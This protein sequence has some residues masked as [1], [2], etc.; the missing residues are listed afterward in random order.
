MEE[1][2]MRR[3]ILVFIAVLV[4]PILI[5]LADHFILKEDIH[6]SYDYDTSAKWHQIVDNPNAYPQELIDLALRNKETIS[7]VADY[8][9]NHEKDIAINIQQEIQSESMPLFMQWDKRWGYKMYGDQMMAIDG[10]GPTCLSMVVSYLTQNG[11]Y[12]P[13]YM[14]QYSE[15]NGYYSEAGTAW[16]LMVRGAQACGID[17]KEIHLDK[18]TVVSNLLEGHP[19]ICSVSKGTFTSTGHFIVL[20]EYKNHQI[21]VLDPN[22]QKKSGY[23]SF[24]DLSYQIRNLW[25]YSQNS[26]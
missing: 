8:P 16:P 10:C 18:K 12:H 20:S 2:V 14:A 26:F 5:L 19:I 23:Y 22:S 21:K 6:L 13:Y 3:K 17:V 7:F 11:R 9:E 25:A 24:D 4:I 15:Q 1:D